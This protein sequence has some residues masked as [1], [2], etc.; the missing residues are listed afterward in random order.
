MATERQIAANRRNAL[1]STGPRT[2]AGKA[3]VSRNGLRHGVRARLSAD[4]A[5]AAE[6]EKLAHVIAGGDSA[7]LPWARTAAEAT[8]QL[9]QVRR[10]R[11]ILIEQLVAGRAGIESAAAAEARR[12][13]QVAPLDRYERSAACRRDSSLRAIDRLRR[14]GIQC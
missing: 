1:K 14:G 9:A 4:P 10:L 13:L 8:L 2:A 12:R 7:V 6:I 11:T 5:Y 3:R